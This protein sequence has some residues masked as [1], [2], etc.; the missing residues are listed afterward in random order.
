[1]SLTA[2]HSEINDPLAQIIDEELAKIEGEKA[3]RALKEV[4]EKVS[5]DAYVQLRCVHVANLL[6]DANSTLRKALICSK[7]LRSLV[8]EKQ[9]YI[10]STDDG[11]SV[12]NFWVRGISYP[13]AVALCLAKNREGEISIQLYWSHLPHGYQYRATVLGY[14]RYAEIP[15]EFD[16]LIEELTEQSALTRAIVRILS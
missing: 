7:R 9:F 3:D 2:T 6:I 12:I 4:E 11:A 14:D 1:M 15:E 10:N 8:V 5:R 13:R 16:P